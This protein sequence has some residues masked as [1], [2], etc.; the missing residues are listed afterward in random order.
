MVRRL[1]HMLIPYCRAVAIGGGTLGLI[2]LSLAALG[3]A[4]GQGQGNVRPYPEQ[5]EEQYKVHPTLAIGSPAPDFT[6]PG[7]DGK[8]HSL[9]EYK[10]SSFLAVVFL[11]NHC[12]ASQ[13]YE[14]R[15]KRMVTEYRPKGVDFVAIQ[16][17]SPNAVW[18]RQLNCTD[19][20]DTLEGM[21]IRA[22]YQSFNFPYLY[23]GETQ[24][25]SHKYGPKVT[26]QIFIFDRERKLR[27]EGRIDDNQRETS[28][29]TQDARAALDAL[30]AD[31][32]VAVEHTPVVG[33][34]T[35]WESWKEQLETRR[36]EIKEW[37]AQPVTLEMATAAD[38]K[39]LRANPTGKV[40]MVN[41]WATWCGPCVAEMPDLLQTY[42]W[43]RSR[44]FEFVTVSADV[45]EAKPAV[46]KLLQKFHS[47]VRNLQFASD[48]TYALQAAFDSKWDSGVPFTIVIAPDGKVIYKQEGEINIFA[49]RR[50]I[51]ANLPDGSF[52]GNAA[53]WAKKL[54]NPMH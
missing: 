24:G 5:L 15:V 7:V 28:E 31:R 30:L 35:K 9:S 38:L 39:K 51:L 26:P 11:S 44:D 20:E 17:N 23:D 22:E 54:P 12:P 19:V 47:A 13:L 29:T 16:P 3:L 36:Q 49:L 52:L 4:Q 40:L 50:A 41:F 46:L 6:L 32:P 53:Y 14:D 48:N 34:A 43:Y 25:V 42:L 8:N 2:V 10:D 21:K 33:C 1:V 37:E 45:P 18:P 27:Y